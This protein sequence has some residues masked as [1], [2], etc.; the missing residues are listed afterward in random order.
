MININELDDLIESSKK[1]YNLD[2]NKEDFS[3]GDIVV[4][5]DTPH[6]RSWSRGYE[7][8]NYIMIIDLPYEEQYLIDKFNLFGYATILNRENK[9]ELNYRKTDIRHASKEE[10]NEYNRGIRTINKTI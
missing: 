9:F 7:S 1:L 8:I 5:L 2:I 3:I 4:V 6:I 10:I